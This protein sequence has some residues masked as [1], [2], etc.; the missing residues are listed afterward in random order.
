MAEGLARQL[1]GGRAR[2][3]SAGSQPSRVNPCAVKVMAE[4]G[5]DLSTHRSKSGQE[6]DPATED[7]VITLCAEEVCPAFLGKARRL[8]RPLTDPAS[9]TPLPDEVLRARFRDVRDQLRLCLERFASKEWPGREQG[10]PLHALP[11]SCPRRRAGPCPPLPAR[12]LRRTCTNL[13]SLRG[14]A[15]GARAAG[16]RRDVGAR[17]PRGAAGAHPVWRRCH[18][19]GD[20]LR[21]GP[22]GTGRQPHGR[23]GGGARGEGLH[24]AR[25]GAGG[26]ALNP[27]LGRAHRDR[28]GRLPAL[29]GGRPRGRA[30]ARRLHRQRAERGAPA[31]PGAR[32]V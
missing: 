27:R 13:R 14:G 10:V 8:H 26:R 25:R 18:P 23:G 19:D 4:L 31:V 12:A 9:P 16:R 28:L 20:R 29:R 3:Q 11:S 5:I 24:R 7:T 30:S 21:G 6:I 15:G 22:L 32:R 2:V 17:H 1:L